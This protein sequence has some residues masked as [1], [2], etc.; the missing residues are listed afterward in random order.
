MRSAWGTR[1]EPYF[2]GHAGP[3]ALV[4]VVAVMGLVATHAALAAACALL[5]WQATADHYQAQLAR[6]QAE[7]ATAQ[8]RAA[9]DAQAVQ[10]QFQNQLQEARN[11]AVKREAA[12]RRD[13]GAARDAVYGLRGATDRIRRELPGDSAAAAAGAA[14]AAAELLATCA[15]RYADV[16]AA[17]DGH[18]HDALTLQQAWPRVE[19]A[20]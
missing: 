3:L 6:L 10:I 13:V 20:P 9:A 8:A 7:H 1:H 12:L 15:G 14:D 5:T 18:A 16:A 19:G 4:E 11:A 17:A 2:L